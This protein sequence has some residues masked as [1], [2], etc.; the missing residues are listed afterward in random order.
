MKSIPRVR[1]ALGVAALLFAGLLAGCDDEEDPPEPIESSSEPTSAPTSATT[2]PTSTGPV[3][4]TLP[5]EAEE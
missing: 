4:P 1:S 5:P 2:E 3:E